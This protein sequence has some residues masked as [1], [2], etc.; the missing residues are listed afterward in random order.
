MDFVSFELAKKLK[1]KWYPQNTFGCCDMLGACYIY[2]GRFYKDG[3]IVP[4]DK[5][6]SAPTISQVLKWLREMKGLHV[7]CPFYKDKGYYYYVQRLGDAARIVSSFDD[8]DDC[9]NE[10]KQAELAG[11]E[12]VL[13]N[14]I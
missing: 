7:V 6:F 8:S 1:E 4:V 12:Y 2:D 13:D 3:C 11:I 10:Y 14:L 5:A 9:F